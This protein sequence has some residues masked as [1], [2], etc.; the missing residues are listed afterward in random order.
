MSTAERPV[1]P[2]NPF[3]GLNYHYGMLLGVDDLETEQGFHHG[4]QRLHNAWL[5]R[6][7]VVWGLGV[8]VD[9][10]GRQLRVRPGLA[11]DAAG[12]A[13]FL[14]RVQCLTDLGAWYDAH[15]GEVA[16]R[17][18][19]GGVEFTAHVVI[20]H[21][22]CLSRPVPALAEPCGEGGAGDLTAF[23]RVVET[24]EVLLLPGGAP[25]PTEPYPRARRLFGLPAPATDDDE[26]IAAERV[27]IA[28]LPVER[29]PAAV[30]D[31]LRRFAARDVTETGPG[32]DDR[33][34][35]LALFPAP[36]GTPV[37][38]A[39][40]TVRLT[41]ARGERTLRDAV[42]DPSVR[43]AHVATATIQELLC[44]GG[45][46]GPATAAGPRAVG[47]ARGVAPTDLTLT[48]DAPL[49]AVTVTPP[50]FAVSVFR[51]GEGWST[52]AITGATLGPDGTAVTLS[53]G[54]ELAGDLI[55]IVAA[56]TGSAP[57]LG[58][59]LRPL[60]GCVGDPPGP[61]GGADAVVHLEGSDR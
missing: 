40:L 16:A 48:F 18:V 33:G 34:D 43:P 2:A 37:A 45:G 27:R 17:R 61:A 13:L 47:A 42:V 6:D 19:G 15:A 31:A 29:R 35:P 53:V 11:L 56:G 57:V 44:G 41:G 28:G 14:E 36:D 5:H 23:S 1:L 21:R 9:V 52:A 59:D 26:A 54:E 51:A 8:E 60:A 39:D 22:P 20:R 4:K 24:V 12:C 55:R 58:T 10:P 30:R 3:T 38:L 32:V 25:A 7:G 46:P 50:A 49:D